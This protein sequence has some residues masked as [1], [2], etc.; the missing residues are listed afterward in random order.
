MLF[1]TPLMKKKVIIST[2]SATR[3]TWPDIFDHF[4]TNRTKIETK[5]AIRELL[6]ILL[7]F[8]IEQ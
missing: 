5:C 7:Y 6:F 8:F 3:K 1:V 2:F 4:G